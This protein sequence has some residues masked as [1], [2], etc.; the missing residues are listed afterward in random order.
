MVEYMQG[1]PK[2]LLEGGSIDAKLSLNF[3][4]LGGGGIY[5]MVEYMLLNFVVVV[6]LFLNFVVVEYMQGCP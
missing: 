4:F 1:C 6:R 3:V 5:I 2:I